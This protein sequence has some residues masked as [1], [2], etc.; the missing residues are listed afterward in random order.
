MQ[1]IMMGTGPYAVPTFRALHESSHA[2]SG[3]F[4]R[5]S[6]AR[7]GRRRAA[8]NPMRDFAEANGITVHHPNDVNA[9]QAQELLQN[10][11]PDLLVVCDYGQ[12]LAVETLASAR[13]GGFNLHASLL[14][15][16]RG[17]AP[18]NWAIYQGETETG[19]TVIHMTPRVDAGPCVAQER[20]AIG[21]DETAEVLEQRLAESGAKLVLQAVDDLDADTLQQVVQ[22]PQ[23]ATRAPKLKKSDGHI[24]WSRSAE[25]IRNQIRAMQPWPKSFTYWLR[26]EREH[27]RLIIEKVCVAPAIDGTPGEVIAVEGERLEVATGDGVLRIDTLQPAGKRALGASDFLR[28]YPVQVGDVFGDSA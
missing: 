9:R 8:P 24:D 15:K 14:P 6:V 20:I 26:D 2:V 11:E 21:V 22:D 4:T 1:L 12:I 23:K 7:S 16:Y 5:P 28:G 25:Q 27:L 3:L 18:I 13:F 10:L 19:N 17:A